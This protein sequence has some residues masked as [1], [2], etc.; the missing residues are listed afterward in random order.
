MADRLPDCD[1]QL[2]LQHMWC[3]RATLNGWWEEEEFVA[4]I[5]CIARRTMPDKIQT[6]STPSQLWER[7]PRESL[8]RRSSVVPRSEQN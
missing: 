7:F 6:Q 5:V 2:A 8:Q 1:T 3:R 4:Q